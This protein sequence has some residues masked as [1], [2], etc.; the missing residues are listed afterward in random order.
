MYPKGKPRCSSIAEKSGQRVTFVR[1]IVEFFLFIW[2]ISVFWTGVLSE[3]NFRVIKRFPT[4]SAAC[5]MWLQRGQRPKYIKHTNAS[6]QSQ[7]PYLSNELRLGCSYVSLQMGPN[8]V[9][10][11]AYTNQFVKALGVCPV[12]KSVSLRKL[13]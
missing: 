12:G 9:N 13:T 4:K 11:S 10:S 8:P 5:F 1:K 7:L 2:S 6:G 3:V